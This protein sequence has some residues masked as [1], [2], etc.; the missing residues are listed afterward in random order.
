M[1]RLAFEDI[2]ANGDRSPDIEI[3]LPEIGG[4]EKCLGKER[5][6]IMQIKLENIRP[7]NWNPNQMTPEEFTELVAEIKHLQRPPKPIVLR[8]VKDY[9][10][11]VDGEHTYKALLENKFT[12]LKDGW[13]EL[14]DVNDIEAMRQTYKRN[15]HGKHDPIK[16]GLMFQRVLKETGKSNRDLAKEWELSE[17]TVR[18]SLMYAEVAELRND[19][20]NI[21]Q[22]SV[23]QIRIYSALVKYSKKFAD[24]WLYCGGYKDALVIWGDNGFDWEENSQFRQESVVDNIGYVFKSLEEAGFVKNLFYKDDFIPNSPDTKKFNIQQFKDAINKLDKALRFKNELLQR[25]TWGLNEED[26]EGRKKAK[27]IIEVYFNNPHGYFNNKAKSTANGILE[28]IISIHNDK[29]IFAIT[30]A[31]L[32]EALDIKPGEYYESALDKVRLFIAK[33]LDIAPSEVDIST[34]WNYE[35]TIE[36]KLADLELQKTAP[37]WLK[38]AKIPAKL[39]LKFWIFFKDKDES[40]MHDVFE[41]INGHLHYVMQL[42]NVELTEMFNRKFSEFQ[43]TLEMEKLKNATETELAKNF[44]DKL[45]LTP[46]ENKELEGRFNEAICALFSKEALYTLYY[47]AEKVFKYEHFMEWQKA[48]MAATN[49]LRK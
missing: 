36:N 40:V 33:K 44:M 49:N 30:P 37:D 39:K 13:Y 6:G 16:Q 10:E 17:G 14:V 15:Q 3:V 9:Y 42:K 24:F 32:E 5:I 7:N 27:E 4:G 26:L 43:Q 34:E 1:Y 47:L 46:K 41:W 29:R 21:A 22:L 11:I 2:F 23:E 35:D 38:V 20:A 25:F 19:Y 28:A 31:E 45:H 8:K 18:N 12:E 48:F